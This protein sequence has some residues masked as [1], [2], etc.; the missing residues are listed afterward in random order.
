ML[1]DMEMTDT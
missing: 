1:A